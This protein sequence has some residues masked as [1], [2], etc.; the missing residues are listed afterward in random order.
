MCKKI[1]EICP[2]TEIYFGK[3]NL[4]EKYEEKIKISSK[5][6]IY[7]TRVFKR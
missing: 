3:E 7:F 6:M 1:K 5:L 4:N 2:I